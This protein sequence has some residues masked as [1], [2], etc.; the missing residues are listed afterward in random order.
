MLTYNRSDSNA[1]PFHVKLNNPLM[2]TEIKSPLHNECSI[3]LV[4][5]KLNNPLKG[6]EILHLHLT[7]Y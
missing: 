7:R 3:Y 4:L 6:A 2:G 1:L 5:V